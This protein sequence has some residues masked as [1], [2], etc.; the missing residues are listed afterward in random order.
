MWR[1]S[2]IAFSDAVGA[3]SCSVVPVHPWVYGQGQ[4]TD[5][6]AYLSPQNAINYLAG[7]LTGSSEIADVTVFMLSAN[8]HAEFMDALDVMAGVFPIPAFTK[9]R[10]MAQA[11]AELAT[12][13][14][15]IPP[16]AGN[17]LPAA[18]PLSVSTG[19]QA[20][21]AARIVRAKAEA[22]AG[23]SAGNM[24]A[25]LSGFDKARNAALAEISQG[26]DALKSKSADAW[27]FTR[28]GSLNTTATEMLKDIPAAS[29]VHCVAVMFVGELGALEA[30]I[31]DENS[32]ART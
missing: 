27:V 18:A 6:G 16:S 10:R 29:A 30:M 31:H 20:V 23:A 25:A 12:V 8:S 32:S 21:N 4:H 28:T 17:G 1:K 7:K 3:L 24:A 9:V 19:R 15:Q 5:S 13:K 14:M 26:L 2:K 22:A 11:A